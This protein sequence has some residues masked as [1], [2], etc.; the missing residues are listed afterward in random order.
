MQLEVELARSD[1]E[2]AF[3]ER[4]E[5]F[6]A[7]IKMDEARILLNKLLGAQGPLSMPERQKY[8]TS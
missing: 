3:K 1:R 8:L 6:A 5:A 2:K 4:T 7:M